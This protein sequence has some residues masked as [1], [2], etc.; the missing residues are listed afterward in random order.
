MPVKDQIADHVIAPAVVL[1]TTRQQS[2]YRS[3]AAPVMPPLRPICHQ[4]KCTHAQSQGAMLLSKNN[5]QSGR[6]L[7]I[8]IVFDATEQLRGGDLAYRIGQKLVTI[9]TI[10]YVDMDNISSVQRGF[11]VNCLHRIGLTASG[12]YIQQEI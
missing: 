10:F 7:Y 6:L 9:W 1:Q 11:Q 5:A 4:D 8:Y 2:G 12:V 3:P